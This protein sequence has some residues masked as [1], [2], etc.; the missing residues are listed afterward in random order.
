MTIYEK[1]FE[2]MQEAEE[3]SGP[4]G[5]E[6]MKLM[7]KIAHEALSRMQTYRSG[8]YEDDLKKKSKSKLISLNAFR[9]TGK[10]VVFKNCP[11]MVGVDI[12]NFMGRIY[13]G[14]C[15]IE[16]TENG[17]WHLTL[18]N[19]EYDSS[20]VAKLEDILYH[21]FYKYEIAAEY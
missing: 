11:E 8:S 7:T 18:Y 15:F 3:L 6:Y 19:E 20:D 17:R 12:E 5:D 16:L 4:I 21:D 14:N 1:V 2:A 9:A 10:N 13:A